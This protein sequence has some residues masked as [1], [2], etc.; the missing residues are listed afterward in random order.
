MAAS[1]YAIYLFKAEQD[2]TTTDEEMS[3]KSK[4]LFLVDWLNAYFIQLLML[5][6]PYRWYSI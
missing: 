3:S 1:L 2:S 4:Y 5:Y 6:V